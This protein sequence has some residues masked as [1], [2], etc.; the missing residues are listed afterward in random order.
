M[1]SPQ[2]EAVA[3]R[4]AV[5]PRGGSVGAACAPPLLRASKHASQLPHSCVAVFLLHPGT[6]TTERSRWW[7]GRRAAAWMVLRPGGSSVQHRAA[8]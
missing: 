7:N 4:R 3:A 8:C 2:A 1:G 6:T 5:N